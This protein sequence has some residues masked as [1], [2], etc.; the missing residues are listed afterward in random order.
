MKPHAVARACALLLACTTVQAQTSNV[1]SVVVTGTRSAERAFDVPASIDR[2]DG[3]ALRD[4]QW[5][6]NL[7]EGVARVPGL[8]V[9]NRQ[10]YAQD[11]QVSSRG[12]GARATFGVRGVRLIQDGIPLTMPDG[13]G[14][15]ALLDLEGAGAIEVL[16]GPFAALYGNASGGVIHVIGDDAPRKPFVEGSVMGGSDS[17]WRTGVRFG[18][19][20]GSF[21]ATGNV[22]RFET[23]GSRDHSAA[24][25]D[26]ANARLRFGL[27]NGASIVVIA[28]AL[29]Q[30]DTQDPLGLTQAQLDADPR[31]A[32]TN[33]LAQDTRKSIKHTQGGLVWRHPQLLGGAVEASVYGGQR[34]LTQYLGLP[35]VA[36]GITSSGG[37]VDLDRNFSGT[38]LQWRLGDEQR[39]ITVGLAYDRMREHRQGFV[40]NAGT[41]GALRRDEDDTVHSFDQFIIGSWQ[42]APAWKLTGGLRHSVVRFESKDRFITGAN[43]D[44][45][46][47]ARYSATSPVLGVLHQLSPDLH[48]FASLGR[49]F[50]TPTFAELAY[51]SGGQPG[52]NFDLAAAKSR[53]FEAGVKA[54]L[55]SNMRASAVVFR[56]DTRNE[57]VS[58]GSSGGRTVYANAGK[59]RREGLELSMDATLPAGF[60]ATLAYTNTRAEYRDLVTPAGAD[61]SGKRIPGVPRQVLYGELGWRHLASGFSS[62]AEVRGASRLSANDT[63]TAQA[64][65]YVTTVLRAGFEQRIGAW[66]LT[67]FARVD[68]LF[69]KDYVGS[70]IVNETNQRYFEPA[71]GRTW[72]LGVTGSYSF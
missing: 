27:D 70:V 26:L 56:A 59:T 47:S 23:N 14:Q 64:P 57:V 69:D 41:A 67:Q 19:S 43:P 39:S 46:G 42:V 1:E 35:L 16:R 8:L 66:K 15:T 32:G 31:Q 5:R 71:P 3:E 37:V 36:Q 49:G 11:L 25:R 38:G 62:A 13:Q 51:R 4:Q 34:Q 33:A 45:S 48:L 29:N 21:G 9:Q 58:A 72:A 50:E 12:F 2:V 10:N 7:S 60:N 30:P 40:N 53:N 6:V 22:S 61:L 18:V 68:N 54:R 24:R 55:G 52:L 28:N 63:N 65:G 17:T 20:S 44:D